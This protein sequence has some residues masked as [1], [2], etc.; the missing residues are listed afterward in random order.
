MDDYVLRIQGI[1]LPDARN[2]D[3]LGLIC[4]I[5]PCVSDTLDNRQA[6]ERAAEVSAKVLQKVNDRSD[7]PRVLFDVGIALDVSAESMLLD[8]LSMA[9]FC[10]RAQQS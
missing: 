6:K 1:V 7:G 5:S 3:K 4:R 8:D 10:V 9:S 2:Y